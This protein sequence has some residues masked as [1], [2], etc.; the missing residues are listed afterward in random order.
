M[1]GGKSIARRVAALLI[2]AVLFTALVS[3]DGPAS[4]VRERYFFNKYFDTL[5]TLQDFSGGDEEDFNRR[6]TRV[7]EIFD[8]YHKLFDIYEEYDGINNIATL[9]R[10]AGKGP[11]S[12]PRELIDFLLFCKEMH[13]LTGGEVNVAMGAV[14]SIWHEHRTAEGEKTLPDMNELRF[15]A[16]HTDID[17]LVIDRTAGTAEL[18][19]P[20]MRLDVGAM[21]K[22]YA[23]ERAAEYLY[24]DRADGFV[25]NAGGNLR[26]IGKKPDGTEWKS[27]VRNPDL[28]D[29]E[30]RYVYSFFFSD[31]SAV[32]SGDYERFFVVDGVRYHHIIDGDTLMP[33]A[34]FSSVTVI[35]AD[36]GVADA[37]TT[38]L[39]NMDYPS[40]KALIES[41]DG[42][43]AVWITR[44][45]EILE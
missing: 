10:L 14:L 16:E 34:H 9:N 37:L 29:Y 27:A 22:G 26:T 31:G 35:T 6:A 13:E 2:V 24:S 18:L 30:N 45:G 19:D 12:V 7:E 39:F 38:A 15:A 8:Y 17:D 42:T 32:T 3:C 21:A 5:T 11:V 28:S 40:G 1:R 44:T 43:R 20:E 25:I 23:V 36:S 41:L 33:S 4:D